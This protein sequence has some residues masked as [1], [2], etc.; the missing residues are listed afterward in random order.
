MRGCLCLCVGVFQDFG[1]VSSSTIQAMDNMVSGIEPSKIS[2]DI[3]V[4]ELDEVSDAEFPLK[5]SK[6][7][8]QKLLDKRFAIRLFIEICNKNTM[9]CYKTNSNMNV[10]FSIHSRHVRVPSTH[11]AHIHTQALV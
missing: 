3:L 7:L 6:E 9:S 2:N 5:E 4:A 1:G 8:A 10:L 11:T